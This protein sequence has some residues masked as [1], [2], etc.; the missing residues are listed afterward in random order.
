MASAGYPGSYERKKLISGLDE[1]DA[2]DSVTVFHA[3]TRFQH[4]Q[5]LTDGGRVL[6]V[7]ATGDTFD[8]AIAQAYQAVE[9]IEFEGAYYRSDIG[10]RIRATQ[11]T[12]L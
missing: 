1:A 12:P 6:G 3:G 2:L 11:S 7:T 9:K 10:Y 4:Q 5:V 8:A